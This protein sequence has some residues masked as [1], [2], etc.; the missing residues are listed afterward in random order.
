MLRRNMIL[1]LSMLVI[2]PFGLFIIFGMSFAVITISI[3]C[4]YAL[5]YF[6]IKYKGFKVISKI[7]EYL[8]IIFLISFVIILSLILGEL[9]SNDDYVDNIDYIVILGAGLEGTELSNTLKQRLDT[10]IE[11][12]ETNKD[13][14]IIL[15][16]GQGDG[17]LIPE[18]VAMGDYLLKNGVKK[19]RLIY[20]SKSMTT[21]ENL[22]NSKE[23]INKLETKNPKI[24]IVTSDYHM[25]RAKMIAKEL[26]IEAYGISSD[27][28]LF[29]RINYIIREYFAIIKTIAS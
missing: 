9:N 29:V 26:S 6:L 27:S 14:K 13:V 21:E 24:I 23:I 2:L 3:I 17:E 5:F 15:S 10:S 12:I 1:T 18:S 7:M 4:F 19:D 22:L 8:F 11:Y 20:E 28:P 25:Y 16:G